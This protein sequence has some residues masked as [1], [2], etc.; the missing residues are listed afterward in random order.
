MKSDL[1]DRIGKI[2]VLLCDVD[3]VL[4]DGGIILDD[5]GIETKRF[6][7]K[8][9]HGIKM[10]QRAGIGV[11]LLTGRISP[12]V[13]YRAAELN[14]TDVIQGATDKKAAYNDLKVQIGRCDEEIAYIGDDVVD[15]PILRQVGVA[16][17]VRDAVDE[18]KAIA[19]YVTSRSGGSG[20]VREVAE[21]ILKTQQH[22]EL[23]M[24]R[25]QA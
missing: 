10:L 24:E 23:L 3:G 1:S 17:A 8:D 13:A 5:H 11:A 2:R 4:T 7:V 19:D 16:I 22:W 12:V 9:G 20:A 18:V 21:L 15:L 6:D 25:Y 14:I